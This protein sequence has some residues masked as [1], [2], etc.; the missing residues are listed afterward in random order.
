MLSNNP[1]SIAS[2]L[3]IMI[4]VIIES[5]FELV[6]MRMFGCLLCYNSPL[7]CLEVYVMKTCG[8]ALTL[9]YLTCGNGYLNLNPLAKH[10]LTHSLT[11]MDVD[12][13]PFQLLGEDVNAGV[14][15]YEGV[16]HLRLLVPSIALDHYVLDINHEVGQ[17]SIYKHCCTS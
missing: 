3:V 15:L 10:R 12:F 17:W 11:H 1:Q 4:M 9:L 13:V 8:L 7:N 2:K 6:I 5:A 14:S 16:V